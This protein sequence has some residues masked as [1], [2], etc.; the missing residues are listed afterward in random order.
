VTDTYTKPYH[1]RDPAE[2]IATQEKEKKWKYL[3]ACLEQRHHFTPFVS[4]TNDLLGREA[5]TFAK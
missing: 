2:V 3:E 5:T 4:S 1:H